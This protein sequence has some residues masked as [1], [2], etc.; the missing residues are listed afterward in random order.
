MNCD[1]IGLD[2]YLTVDN[3]MPSRTLKKSDHAIW[4]IELSGQI[5]HDADIFTR[6]RQF[7]AITIGGPN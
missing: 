6:S 4:L 2:T 1:L 5:H 7:A 3:V